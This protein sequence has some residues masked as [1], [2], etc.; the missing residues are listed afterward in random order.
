[1]MAAYR[2]CPAPWWKLM[3]TA[4]ACAT[5]NEP[6]SVHSAA[7]KTS[8]TPGRPLLLIELDSATRSGLP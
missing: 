3:P 4:P 5:S 2:F 6:S 7:A 1:M 8:D